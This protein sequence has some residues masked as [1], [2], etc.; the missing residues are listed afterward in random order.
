MAQE[1]SAPKES[2]TLLTVEVLDEKGNPVA[3]AMVGLYGLF[4]MGGSQGRGYITQPNWRTTDASGKVVF[5]PH[6]ERAYQEVASQRTKWLLLVSAPGYLPVQEQLKPAVGS[7]YT[8]RLRRGRPLEITLLNET[9]KPLPEPLNIAIFRLQEDTFE[10]VFNYMDYEFDAQGYRKGFRLYSEFGLEPLGEGR[11]RCSL[12][13]DWSGPLLVMVEHPGFLRGFDA[14]IDAGSVKQG[15][16]E[17]RLPKPCRLE[18]QADVSRAPKGVYGRFT[19]SLSKSVLTPFSMPFGYNPVEERVEKQRTLVLDDLSPGEYL[20]DLIGAPKIAWYK[21][22]GVQGGQQLF[23]RRERVML[24][25]DKPATLRLAYAPPDPSKYRGDQRFTITVLMPDGKP[26]A[27][28]PYTLFVRDEAQRE[29]KVAEGKLDSKGRATLTQLKERVTYEL[30]IANREETA[31][32]IYL[33]DPRYKT[34]TT[35]RVP[36]CEG[37][38]A[39]NIT[40]Y[41]IEGKDKKQL[42]DYRGKW[43]Y[44]DFWATWCGP[45]R[46]AL[47]KLKAQLPMLKE[48]LK[49]K[50]VVITLSIDDTPDPVKPYLTKMGLWDACYHFWAG[51]GGWQSPA[52]FAFGIRSV[53]TAFLINPK[54]IITWR[55][56]PAAFDLLS[57]IK[58]P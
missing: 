15:R 11:Y 12:P 48:Q 3:N 44:I 55:G 43:V 7:T 19:V 29:V 13:E 53:P 27:N 9:G 54:G 24:Q 4:Q 40:L 25:P 46:Y 42:K 22:Q 45:C 47:E 35:F 49:D 41:P 34:P 6:P 56:H 38:L 5:P 31:G 2:E 39:P 23:Y 10:A 30:R 1:E 16:A 50:L 8:V 14:V 20:V 33:G 17:I 28:Q 57:K 26:A 37:D 21:K 18:I 32:M 58:E 36:P 52:A 51:E